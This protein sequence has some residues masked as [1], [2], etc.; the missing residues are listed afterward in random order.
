M[1]ITEIDE[2]PEAEPPAATPPAAPA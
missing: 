2:P 1:G